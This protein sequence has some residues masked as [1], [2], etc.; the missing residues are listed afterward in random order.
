MLPWSSLILQISIRFTQ[1]LNARRCCSTRTTRDA[2]PSSSLSLSALPRFSLCIVVSC[3]RKN[4]PQRIVDKSYSMKTIDDNNIY[5]PAISVS[6]IFLCRLSSFPLAPNIIP[7]SHLLFSFHWVWSSFYHSHIISWPFSSQR[8]S[9]LFFS[10]LAFHSSTQVVLTT[11]GP[12]VKY[13]ILVVEACAEN[14][15]PPNAK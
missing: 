9:S 5:F 8:L 1:W 2:S 3:S 12:Y 10:L 4:T 15:T 14:G 6:S 11:V 7:C 13:G